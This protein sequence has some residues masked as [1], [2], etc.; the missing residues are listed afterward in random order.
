MAQA[1]A[2]R[3]RSSRKRVQLSVR[4]DSRSMQLAGSVLCISRT[5]LFLCSDYLDEEGSM[6]ALDLK[7]PTESE[8]VHLAGRVARAETIAPSAGMG[9]QFTDLSPRSKVCITRFL[10]EADSQRLS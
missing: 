5:G 6:V 1:L 8:C 4:Y 7:L 9:I 10:E 2:A 3:R